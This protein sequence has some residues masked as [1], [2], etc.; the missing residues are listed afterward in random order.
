MALQ[1]RLACLE[2]RRG[3]RPMRFVLVRAS[4]PDLVARAGGLLFVMCCAPPSRLE[5]GRCPA[6]PRESLAGA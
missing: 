5:D 4:D 2:Q 3:A 6:A 1:Q